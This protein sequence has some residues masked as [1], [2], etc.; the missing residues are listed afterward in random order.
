MS[1]STQIDGGKEGDYRKKSLVYKGTCLTCLEKGP[2]SEIDKE[3]KVKL[4][5]RKE[6]LVLKA[7]I[8]ANPVLEPTLGVDST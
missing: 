6:K 5:E 7:Y 8:G 4:L 1:D 2:R 3:G